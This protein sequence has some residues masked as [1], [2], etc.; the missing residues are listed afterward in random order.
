MINQLRV[1]QDVNLGPSRA[2]GCKVGK[3]CQLVM[4]VCKDKFC[5][6]SAILV[7]N[8]SASLEKWSQ[9]TREVWC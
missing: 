4:Q 6:Y 9:Q 2:V 5:R 8:H 3:G 7:Y 1:L